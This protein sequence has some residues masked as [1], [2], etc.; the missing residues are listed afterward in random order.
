MSVLSICGAGGL[1]SRIADVPIDI[2]AHSTQLIQEATLPLYHM[3][4][5]LTERELFD[6]QEN[7]K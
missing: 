7:E 4:V 3:L 5:D 2:P 6:R 1:L